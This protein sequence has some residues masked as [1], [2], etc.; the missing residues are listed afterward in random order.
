MGVS[1]SSQ[2]LDA[3][4]KEESSPEAQAISDQKI[5]GIHRTV[6][7]RYRTGKRKPDIGPATRLEKLSNGRVPLTGWEDIKSDAPLSEGAQDEIELDDAAPDEDSAS[8][9]EGPN[10]VNP[11]N[12]P[13]SSP[14]ES[15]DAPK[16]T[17]PRHSKPVTTPDPDGAI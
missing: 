10:L 11:V 3:L 8:G 2:A 15:D 4:L 6:L 13:S 14:P 12:A 5:S 9:I 16:V 17:L 7:W 1:I